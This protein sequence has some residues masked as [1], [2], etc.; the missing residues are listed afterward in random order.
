MGTLSSGIGL[1]SGLDINQM[2]QRLISLEARPRDIVRSKIG[3]IDTQKTALLDLSARVSA[4][5]SRIGSLTQASTFRARVATSSKPEVLTATA[6]SN[7]AVGSFNFVV[8]QLSARQQ[9]VSRGF[10]SNSALLSPG[11]FTLES[12]KARVNR[13]TSLAELNGMTGVQRGSFS[14]ADASGATRTIDVSD[15]VSLREVIDKINGANIN[16]RADMRDDAL[17]L[18]ETTGG[19]VRIDEINGGGVAASLG[20]AQGNTTATGRLTGSNLMRLSTATALSQLNDGNGVQRARAGGDFRFAADGLDIDVDLSG[21]IQD[22]TRV[23][24]LNQGA[25][26]TLGRVRIVTQNDEGQS[27][28]REVDL[29]GKTT[30]GEIKRA[31]EAASPGV[32]VTLSGS[33]ITVGYTQTTADKTIRLEDVTGSSVRDLGLD[34]ASA[35]GRISGRDV[36]KIESLADVV[37]AINFAANNDGSLTAS[38]GARGIEISSEKYFKL[39]RIGNSRA[40]EDLGLTETEFEGTLSGG[41]I[42]GGIDTVLLRT[43]NGGRGA[44]LGTLGITVGG[45]ELSVD[46]RGSETLRDATQKIEDAARAA[47]IELRVGLDGNGTRLTV[48]TQ[49]GAAATIRDIDGD[50]AETTGIATTG[51]NIRGA[52]LQRQYVSGATKLSELNDGRGVA[53]GR[54]RVVGTNGQSTM[55]DVS[56]GGTQTLGE[57]IDRINAAN[58]GVTAR[59]NDT[60]DGLLLQ[61]TAGGA[62]KLRITDENGTAARDL[63]ILGEHDSGSADG[64]FEA[65]FDITN[66]TSLQALV[67]RI[68]ARGTSQATAN[69]IND[70]SPVAPFRLQLTAKNSG[71][72]GEFLIDGLEQVM[73]FSTLSRAQDAKVILGSNAAS[74]IL[75]TSSTDTVRGVA[76]GVDLNLTGVS[77]TAV[78][79]NVAGKLEDATNAIDGLITAFN[80]VFDRIKELSSYNAETEQ[81]GP[82]LGDSAVQALERR[83]FRM[84]GTRSSSSGGAISALSQLGVRLTNGKLSFDKSKFEQAYQREPQGVTD[85]FTKATVGFGAAVKKELESITGAGGLIKRRD[86]AFEREKTDLTKRVEQMNELLQ[87]KQDRLFKQFQTMESSL[88]ALQSQQNALGA[89]FAAASANYAR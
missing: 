11:T 77:E 43:I 51:S 66:A 87:R 64:S 6:S 36:L 60:G 3:V 79:V 15:A 65:R 35:G 23:E 63:N 10:A 71:V 68:N 38:V 72:A 41:R 50:F 16:V 25:G 4:I 21:I 14:I 37:A 28:T 83:L 56:G 17:V 5:L 33:R 1:I 62:G 13:Q 7:A 82:L 52:N 26:V 9:L 58:I 81:G 8:K 19:A 39:E 40:L 20:F 89:I 74:G 18:T 55:I 2:V 29:T 80:Q 24:R 32:S 42:I 88:S 86:Q 73:S 76:P 46:L 59:I 12:S 48:Q 27:V 49:S 45:T 22:G 78:S 31:M 57:L 70:G 61:D 69:L 75:V 67:D 30:V 44:E 47:G 84:I 34:G 54:F 53:G 85:F